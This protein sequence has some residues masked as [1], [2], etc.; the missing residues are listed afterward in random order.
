MA[1]I[2]GILLAHPGLNLA[3]EGYTDSTG[4]DELH[5]LLSEQWAPTDRLRRKSSG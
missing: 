2:P 5:Q 1:K 3:V 4:S